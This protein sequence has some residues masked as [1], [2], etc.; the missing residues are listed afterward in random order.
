M[1]T[2]QENS[3]QTKIQQQHIVLVKIVNQSFI[4]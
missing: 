1:N 3:A 2:I 4:S